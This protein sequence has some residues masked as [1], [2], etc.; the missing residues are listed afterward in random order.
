M[1]NEMNLFSFTVIFLFFQF[2]PILGKNFIWIK[3]CQGIPKRRQE[4][5][6]ENE[7]LFSFLSS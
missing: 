4:L 3:T 5:T 6:R 2:Y 7:L 1:G